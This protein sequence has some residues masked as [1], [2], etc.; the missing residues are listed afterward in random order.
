MF[1]GAVAVFLLV[2]V[3]IGRIPFKPKKGPVL[4]EGT[5][6]PAGP[7]KKRVTGRRL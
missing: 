3:V 7:A 2:C 1:F 4:A 6:A 5:V